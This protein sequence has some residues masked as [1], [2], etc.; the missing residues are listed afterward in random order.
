MSFLHVLSLITWCVSLLG[1]EERF[2]L[3][4][5]PTSAPSR[6]EDVG[7]IDY[8]F[9]VSIDLDEFQRLVFLSIAADGN[10]H[11]GLNLFLPLHVS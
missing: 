9:F 2:S 6:E 7:E 5:L 4:M 11:D 8:S 10:V 1:E 3:A